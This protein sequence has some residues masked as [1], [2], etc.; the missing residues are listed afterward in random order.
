[1]AY[2]VDWPDAEFHEVLPGLYLGGHLWEEGGISRHGKNS[3]VSADK[4][5]DYVVSCCLD[6]V[7]WEKTLPQCDMRLVLFEDTEKGLDN[8]TWVKIW[9]V[10]NEVTFRWWSGE[11]VL[12]RCQAGYNRSGL[13]MS[14][15]LMRL[16]YT[17]EDAIKLCREKRGGDVLINPVFERYV[18]ERE[19]EYRIPQQLEKTKEVADG[20]TRLLL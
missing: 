8:D 20:I 3:S 1:M 9:S 15:I 16:G 14:L 11:K 17:A 18:Y 6:K 4:T 2:N 12:V 19:E 10:V 5:W 7:Y 13:L